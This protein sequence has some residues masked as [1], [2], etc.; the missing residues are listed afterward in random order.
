MLTFETKR[1]TPLG[2][3]HTKFVV[4]FLGSKDEFE[5]RMVENGLNHTVNVFRLSSEE[6]INLSRYI[7]KSIAQKDRHDRRW[8]IVKKG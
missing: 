7:N 2:A 8:K 1:M 6:C 4:E 3:K 5:I